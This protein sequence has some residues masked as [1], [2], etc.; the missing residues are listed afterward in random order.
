VKTLLFAAAPSK[1]AQQRLALR[2]IMLQF[3]FAAFAR[4]SAAVTACCS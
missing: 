3:C 1:K 4:A 2:P